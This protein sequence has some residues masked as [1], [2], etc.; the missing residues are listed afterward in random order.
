MM[1]IEKLQDIDWQQPWLSTLRQSGQ[2]ISQEILSATK[3]E[4]AVLPVLNTYAK[5]LPISF[6][7]QHHLPPDIAYE[8]LINAQG[9]VPTRINSHDFFNA[10]IWLHY[11]Q[12]KL[13]LNQLHAQIIAQYGIG[14]TRQR[15]RDLITLF[16]ENG[17]F[18]ICENNDFITALKS[19][20]WQTVFIDYR[21]QWHQDI[22][23][24]PFGH[25][26]LEKLLRPFKA[27]TAHTFIYIQA[28]LAI[29]DHLHSHIID[30]ARD[31]APG[32]A[33]LQH[34]NSQQRFHPLP[35]MG[36]PGWHADNQQITF[37]QD[38]YVFRGKNH[39]HTQS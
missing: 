27:I 16:D 19:R 11:P 6:V 33:L 1:F 26:L 4:Q 7:P 3:P 2:A 25:A 18:L 32:E 20:D 13:A 15:V 30:D 31:F 37:Y 17:L 14:P 8:S 12:M 29:T 28:D 38:P 39:Q 23:I 21:Q 10:L 22:R 9:T 35:V 24:A 5:N 34:I 36:I